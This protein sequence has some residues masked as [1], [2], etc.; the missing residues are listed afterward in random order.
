MEMAT[1]TVTTTYE[2]DRLHS[3]SF[4]SLHCELLGSESAVDDLKADG[5]VKENGKDDHSG[6][7]THDTHGDAPNKLAPDS[8]RHLL[9]LPTEILLQIIYHLLPNDIH[10]VYERARPKSQLSAA[11]AFASYRKSK[12]IGNVSSPPASLSTI[13]EPPHLYW[14]PTSVPDLLLISRRFSRVLVPVLYQRMKIEVIGPGGDTCRWRYWPRDCGT[15]IELME[16][17]Q[18]YLGRWLGHF[19]E[20]DALMSRVLEAKAEDE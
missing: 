20:E 4:A 13:A 5:P 10:V 6:L 3:T 7:H 8:H 15:W 12:N 14:K 9:T 19:T 18:G 16:E 11:M 17:A 2:E 1:L